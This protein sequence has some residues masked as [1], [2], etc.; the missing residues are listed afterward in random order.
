MSER[1][2]DAKAN[3]IFENSSPTINQT[4]NINTNIQADTLD[5]SSVPA[6][7]GGIIKGGK[8]ASNQLNDT[9]RY[10]YSSGGQ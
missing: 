10:L 7:T 6:I 5:Y 2:I 1:E 9:S 3:R 8:A 4:T